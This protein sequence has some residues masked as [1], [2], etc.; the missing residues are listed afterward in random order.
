MTH[1]ERS[2]IGTTIAHMAQYYGKAVTKE[3]IAMMVLDL[4]DLSVAAVLEAFN[5]YRRDPRNRFFPLPAQVRE[6]INPTP[7]PEQIAREAVSRVQEA[8]SRFGYCNSEQ[9][10]S[11]IGELG[12]GVVKSYGGWSSVCERMGVNLS[13]DTFAAQARELLKAR[14]IHGGNEIAKA[15]SL[16]Y[17][18]RGEELIEGSKQVLDFVKIKEI[19]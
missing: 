10:K 2:K 6:L 14:V 18:N 7:T 13:F 3:V 8:I 11:F 19:K 15:A 12:W 16:S 5:A 1:E 9:A 17:E 4:E